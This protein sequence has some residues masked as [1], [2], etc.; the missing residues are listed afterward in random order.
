[1]E[2]SLT[3]RLVPFKSSKRFLIL[4]L[5]RISDGANSVERGEFQKLLFLPCAIFMFVF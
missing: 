1:M 5:D 3:S 4:T 2:P